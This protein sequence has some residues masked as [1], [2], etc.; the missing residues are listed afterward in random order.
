M[1]H[2]LQPY[3]SA[4]TDDYLATLVV[5]SATLARKRQAQFLQT[6]LEL[7]AHEAIRLAEGHPPRAASAAD[8]EEALDALEAYLRHARGAEP[9]LIA[10]VPDEDARARH[11]TAQDVVYGYAAREAER[12]AQ[13]QP[14]AA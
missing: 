4:G 10:A 8:R 1:M 2:G 6:L 14:R 9:F 13:M 11:E 5:Q 7:A 3:P 12:H